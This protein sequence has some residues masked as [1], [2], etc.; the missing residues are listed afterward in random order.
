[1]ST[2]HRSRSPRAYREGARAYRDGRQHSSCP[3]LLGTVDG[4]AWEAGWEDGERYAATST[5]GATGWVLGALVIIA[6]GML[7]LALLIRGA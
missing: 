7:A 1:V 3:Y 4:D 6:L 5:D 2:S